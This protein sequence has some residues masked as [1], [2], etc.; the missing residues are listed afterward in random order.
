MSK[1]DS[2]DYIHLEEE[3]NNLLYDESIQAIRNGLV[4]FVFD[5]LRQRVRIRLDDI[6]LDIPGFLSGDPN[7]TDEFYQLL[8][9]HQNALKISKNQ[10]QELKRNA[11]YDRSCAVDFLM[12]VLVK[13]ERIRFCE[14]A[15]IAAK[16]WLPF[17]NSTNLT[18]EATLN[19]IRTHLDLTPEEQLEFDR[20]IIRS[21]FYVHTNLRNTVHQL[22][23]NT[24]MTL[25]EFLDYAFIL[26]SAW[27]AFYK[28][29]E[30]PDKLKK[31][32]QATLLKL[33]I[34]FD[35]DETG[36]WNF[37]DTAKSTFA[38]R[39]DLVILSCIRG[40]YTDPIQVWEILDYFAQSDSDVPYYSNLYHEEREIL[41]DKG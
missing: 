14:T 35:L 11:K 26:K 30:E 19:K 39:R 25:T 22:Q 33:V 10:M 27:E 5:R 6:K 40:G 24:G 3:L 34:G 8:Q 13:K 17:E 9:T 31:T 29:N 38:L 36:A 18:G 16:V 28:S 15:G 41:P 21:V 23:K 20:R 37:M 7:K 12:S 2:I 32:S 1:K 4:N